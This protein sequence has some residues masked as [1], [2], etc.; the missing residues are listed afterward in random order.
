M[1][2]HRARKRYGLVPR[3]LLVSRTQLDKLEERGYLDPDLKL[4]ADDILLTSSEPMEIKARDLRQE[5]EPEPQME[6]EDEE[7]LEAEAAAD[8]EAVEE[9]LEPEDDDVGVTPSADWEVD[10]DPASYSAPI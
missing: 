8:P 5:S 1:R 4:A 2:S 9:E 6:L 10:D 3:R 7:E